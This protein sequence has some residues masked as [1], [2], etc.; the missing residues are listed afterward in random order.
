MG[1]SLDDRAVRIAVKDAA[2]N[3]QMIAILAQVI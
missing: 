2:M 3:R 1:T